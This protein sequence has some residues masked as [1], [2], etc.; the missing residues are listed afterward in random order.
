M[1]DTHPPVG[2]PEERAS[3]SHLRQRANSPA[4]RRYSGMQQ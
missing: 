4:D 2:Y 1:M 3:A